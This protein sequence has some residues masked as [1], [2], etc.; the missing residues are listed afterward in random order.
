MDFKI[1]TITCNSFLVF[2]CKAEFWSFKAPPFPQFHIPDHVLAKI[3]AY[4]YEDGVDLLKAWIQTEPDGTAAVMSQEMLSLV[5]LDKSP[6]FIQM[7]QKLSAYH[8]F[9]TKCLQFNNPYALYVHSLV[10]G[11]RFCDLNG[12]IA[13]LD[14]IKNVFPHA[15]LLFIMLH[16]CQGTIP[17]EFY[18]SYKRSYYKFSEV[19]L[20]ADK[21]MY[22]INS[23]GPRRQGTYKA[24]WEFEDYRECWSDHQYLDEGEGQWCNACIYYYL[25]QEICQIS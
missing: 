17:W 22:H 13:V 4:I 25:S 15:G 24:S 5:R 20:F 6:E 7:A 2:E 12:A 3:V 14:G 8:G 16:S 10:L 19:D 18:I 1:I 11:F 21:L 23:V 9:Y